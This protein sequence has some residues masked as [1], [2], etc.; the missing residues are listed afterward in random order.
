MQH[1]TETTKLSGRSGYDENIVWKIV[2]HFAVVMFVKDVNKDAARASDIIDNV[3]RKHNIDEN[4]IL[5]VLISS[6][7]V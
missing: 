3:R 5:E 2:S 4:E 1:E 6:D 7:L